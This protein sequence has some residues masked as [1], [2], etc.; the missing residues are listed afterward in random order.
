MEDSIIGNISRLFIGHTYRKFYSS[1]NGVA[2]ADSTPSNNFDN[3]KRAGF[4]GLMNDFNVYNYALSDA[5]IA[6]LAV[7][8]AIESYDAAEQKASVISAAAGT[9]TLVFADY[10]GGVLSN[11]DIVPVTLIKGV[12]VIA[13]EKL[14]ALGK[15]DKIML[16][17]NMSTLKPICQELVIAQ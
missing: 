16:W 3:T 6:A 8:A 13:Q 1:Y 4:Y 9:A 5:E 12:N 10:E 11:I 7:D 14:F 17:E 15:D 2:N